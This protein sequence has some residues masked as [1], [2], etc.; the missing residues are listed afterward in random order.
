MSFIKYIVD[1]HLT[2]RDACQNKNHCKEVLP[3]IAMENGHC[4]IL[5]CQKRIYS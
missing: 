4:G 3:L 1:E 2:L 5:Q